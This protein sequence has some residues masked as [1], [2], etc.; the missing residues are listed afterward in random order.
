[1]KEVKYLN[2]SQWQLATW[3]LSSFSTTSRAQSSPGKGKTYKGKGEPIGTTPD[4][5]AGAAVE[6]VISWKSLS[7]AFL[8]LDICL[9]LPLL[10]C[11]CH[12]WIWQIFLLLA[13]CRDV[14]LPDMF[15]LD[16][17]CLAL[18]FDLVCAQIF[19]S[20]RFLHTF[21]S[22]AFLYTVFGH[23]CFYTQMFFHSKVFTHRSSYT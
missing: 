3:N 15:S 21:F 22:T 6:C 11:V 14:L 9:M 20:Q 7:L 1:M 4:R 16:L 23:N 10:A 8:A 19:S 13:A 18:S 12:L 2:R 5:L 17:L